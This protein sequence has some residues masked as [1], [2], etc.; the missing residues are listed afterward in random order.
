[1]KPFPES[2]VGTSAPTPTSGAHVLT[3]HGFD[4]MEPEMLW[5][6]HFSQTHL[7]L[8][9]SAGIFLIANKGTITEGYSS[10]PG[11]NHPIKD[12]FC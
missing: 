10:M 2:F 3:K 5:K 11:L 7:Q 1:M 6:S 8:L 9:I 12:A 4:L